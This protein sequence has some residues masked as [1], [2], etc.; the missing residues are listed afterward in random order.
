MKFKLCVFAVLILGLVFAGSAFAADKLVVSLDA[1]NDAT[2][3]I[4]DAAALNGIPMLR[5]K[6]TNEYSLMREVT[7]VTLTAGT[8]TGGTAGA[9]SPDLDGDEFAVQ[10]FQDVNENGIVDAGDTELAASTAATS[11]VSDGDTQTIDLTT[12]L[13][14]AANSSKWIMVNV[15]VLGP[16]SAAD[17]LTLIWDEG[18]ETGLTVEDELGD[19]MTAATDPALDLEDTTTA[20]ENAGDATKVPNILMAAAGGSVTIDDAATKVA[21]RSIGN[22]EQNT[23]VVGFKLTSDAA[24]SNVVDKIKLADGGTTTPS[25][26]DDD[27]GAAYLYRDMGTIGSKDAADILVSTITNVGALTDEFDLNGANS[28]CPIFVAAD[29][30][31]TLLV[32]MNLTGSAGKPGVPGDEDTDT[33]EILA[34]DIAATSTINGGD[35]ITDGPYEGPAINMVPLYITAVETADFDSDGLLDALKITFSDAVND[36]RW[37]SLSLGTD[38]VITDSADGGSVTELAFDS[39]VQ[40]DV[41]NNS[42]I[43][44]QFESTTMTASDRFTD[45]LPRLGVGANNTVWN[46]A[47]N[48][49]L[50]T[51]TGAQ[52]ATAEPTADKAS[53]VATGAYTGDVD[54]NGKIDQITVSFSESMGTDNALSFTGVS[55]ASVVPTFGTNGIYT[56]TSGSVSGSAIVYTI[57]ESGSGVYDSEAT[58]SFRYDPA[59]ASSNLKDT[60]GNEVALYGAGALT[61]QTATADNVAPVVVSAVTKDVWTDEHQSGATG[62][63]AKQPNGR[64]DTIELTFSEKITAG[65][66]LD[67]AAELDAFIDQFTIIHDIDADVTKWTAVGATTVSPIKPAPVIANTG[68]YGSSD[69]NSKLTIYL[70]EQPTGVGMTNGGDTGVKYDFT[71]A[72][73]GTA[74]NNVKDTAATA[75]TMLAVTSYPAANLIDGAAPFIVDGLFQRDGTTPKILDSMTDA[76]VQAAKDDDTLTAAEI[77]TIIAQ[78]GGW[79]DAK[80]GN[81]RT[82]DSNAVTSGSDTNT[83]DGYIDAFH[84]YFSETVH[85]TDAANIADAFTVTNTTGYS[86]IALDIGVDA[87]NNGKVEATDNNVAFSDAVFYGTSS[88]AANKYDTGEIPTVKFIG[89]AT[90]YDGA[91]V[92]YESADNVLAPTVVLTSYDTAKP[93]PVSAIGSVNL[94]TIAVTWSEDVFSSDDGTGDFSSSASNAVFGYDDGDGAGASN[95]S[96][97]VI[98]YTAPVMVIETDA[99][100]TVADVEQDSIWIKND[101]KVYDDADG[102]GNLIATLTENKAGWLTSGVGY[103]IIINDI[104]APTITSATTLDVDGN[105]F[106][107]YIR[108]VFSEDMDD[109]SLASY[110]AINTVTNNSS[111][112]WILEGYTGY[113]RFN[114]YENTDIGKA[115]AFEDGKPVFADNL[116]NDNI[117]YLQLRESEVPPSSAGTTGWAPMLTFGEGLTLSDK[118]P[119]L[120]DTS[121]A[122]Q[123]TDGVGPIPMSAR[124]LTVT[125]LEVTFSEE[126]NLTTVNSGDFNWTLGEAL[127]N[128]QQYIAAISQPT[129]GVIVLETIEGYKWEPYM[130]GTIKYV[131]HPTDAAKEG[132]FDL[133]V[134]T[135]GVPTTSGTYSGTDAYANAVWYSDADGTVDAAAGKTA[136]SLTIST[137]D[138][139]VAVEEAGVPTAFA[140]SENYPNPFNPTTTIEFAIPVAGNVELVI[141]N[142]NGQK[143]RTLVNETKDAGFYKVM[144]DG[145]NEIDETVSSGIYLYRLVSGD[146]N[147]MEK[148]TFIK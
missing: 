65:S 44:V 91:N 45:G 132:I 20:D 53:P 118:K 34:V 75:N 41:T 116:P 31:V 98:D 139:V 30:S 50:L 112:E 95:L 81:I 111:T 82:V 109:A 141:Y 6:I 96:T 5:M 83:G 123:V 3:T 36:A 76:E 100:L 126:I 70:E 72:L 29:S 43:Y 12:T 10:I 115:A 67:T 142:I 2:Y 25:D 122:V 48:K 21:P 121:T 59:V 86:T 51:F 49:S 113:A 134:T 106:V 38:V 114:L 40:G 27:I 119:N 28:K 57:P 16:A 137:A 9:A 89:G 62:F 32:V 13:E 1:L 124:T 19:P 46:V 71:Y 23:A 14:I 94:K 148:M 125:T 80:F 145:R 61:Q 110:Y 8:N 47:G 15:N 108:F 35:F 105:G 140:L 64:I 22:K 87:D 56:P 78:E 131:Q 68:T 120:L 84:I 24:Y 54:G 90:I 138:I 63:E 77:V 102:G 17:N 128:F 37:A 4:S 135:K 52:L 97:T 136:A 79:A 66:G 92:E 99:A 73:S 101:D 42:V 93:V 18:A 133:Q 143:V 146:F 130:G 107:D 7:A 104:I 144:W 127:E 88:K 39:T 58:P 85:V 103:K 26:A 117:L 69:T 55:F 147:K 74:E 129:P 11:L 60:A 33:Q